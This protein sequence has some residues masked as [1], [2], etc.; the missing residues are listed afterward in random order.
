[1]AEEIDNVSLNP[2]QIEEVKDT[3]FQNTTYLKDTIK[4]SP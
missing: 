4:F 3:L 1:M 2:E